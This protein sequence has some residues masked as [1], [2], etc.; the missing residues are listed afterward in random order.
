MTIS[1]P[2]SKRVPILTYH[3]LHAPGVDYATNDHVALAEDLRLIFAEGFRVAPLTD[4]VAWICGNGGV[5]L[6]EGAWIGLSFDDGPD[7]DF[8]DYY[9][10]APQTHIKSMYRIL[11]DANTPELQESR[12]P[13]PT[14]VSFVIASPDARRILDQT[15]I[16][17]RNNWT[18]RW[19]AEAART[20][21]LQIGNHSWDHLHNTLPTVA[22]RNQQKG[23]FHVIDSF[24][25]ADIQVA[26]A[27]KLIRELAG[28]ST[29][30]LFAY[31]YGEAS[32]YLLKEYFPKHRHRHGI[33]AAFVT[34]GDYATEH[35]DRWGIPRFV[36]G[37]H[38]KSP[39]ELTN[40]LRAR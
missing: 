1:L 31:P 12:F 22:Q 25:D 7:W 19:W 32:E 16:A 26:Q 37:E 27:E 30:R 24:E 9:G 8:V 36:C 15:C 13:R 5:Y 40:L 34:G 17:G 6:D 4:I 28:G 35:S 39:E 38:W 10:D 2:R 11:C 14:A 3:S 29:S 18:D 21:V 20:G 23:T 33:T